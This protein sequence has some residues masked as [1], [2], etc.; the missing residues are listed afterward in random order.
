MGA[1]EGKSCYLAG[2]IEHEDPNLPNWRPAVVRELRERFGLNPFDPSADEKQ[3]RKDVLDEA[4]ANEDY[5]LV[6]EIARQFVKKDLSVI[7]RSDVLIACLPYRVATSG[8]NCEI[9]HSVQ[10]KKPT[11]IVCP[12]GK[13]KSS[14]WFFGYIRHRYIYGSWDGLYD[15]LQEVDE[16]KHRDNHRWWYVYN[17]V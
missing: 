13:N 10:L 16:Y 6:E 12:E 11:L 4:L 3:K 5:D 9:H 2:P 1:L 8:T 15:Y 7:D 17:M 14:L